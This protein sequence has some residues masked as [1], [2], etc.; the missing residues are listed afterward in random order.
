[1]KLTQDN[2]ISIIKRKN[3]GLSSRL[4][5]RQYK[6]STRRIEQIWKVYKN[7]GEVPEL[8]K[9]G[10]KPYQVI[11][12][13]M[14][15]R[16]LKVHEKYKMGATLIAKYFRDKFNIRLG[17]SY[18]HMILLKH[19]LAIPNQNKQKRR[20]PWIRYERLHSLTAVHMDWHY[21]SILNKWVCVVLDDASR[22]VLSYGEFDN[23]TTKNSIKLLDEAYEKYKHIKPIEQ[24]ITDHGPQFYANKRNKKGEAIH[25]FELYCKNKGIKLI[26][27]KYKHP[28]TNGKLEK[29]FH[30]YQ[31][32][33][34][35][36]TSFDNF[37]KWYNEVRPHMSLNIDEWETPEKAFWRKAQDIILGNFL[38]WTES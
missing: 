8:K 31:K 38:K 27:C 15:K 32:H 14:E 25:Q 7:T 34:H 9:I 28:Q 29:W 16:I 11:P 17:H 20:K 26:L 23:A 2:I 37:I 24:V 13:D 1:M 33:R 19:N 18:Y 12:R 6:V 5:A 3:K 10:R 30:T 4:I 35:K 22:K 21:N 36:F